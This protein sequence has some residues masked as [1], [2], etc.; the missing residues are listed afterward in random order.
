MNIQFPQDVFEA[1]Q[2]E[3]SKTP[4]NRIVDPSKSWEVDIFSDKV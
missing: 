1:L 2:Q 4:A 3:A